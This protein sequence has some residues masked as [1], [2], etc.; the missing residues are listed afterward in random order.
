M[1][2]PTSAAKGLRSS[3]L[4]YTYKGESITPR[5]I[6][7]T[8]KVKRAFNRAV[9]TTTFDLARIAV[10]VD[11]SFSVKTT[12]IFFYFYFSILSKD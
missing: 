7:A 12:N 9:E 10:Q 8:G 11:R 1:H 2:S 3:F 5:C 6:I 4:V